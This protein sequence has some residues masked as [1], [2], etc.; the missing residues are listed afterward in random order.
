MAN[1]T[2]IAAAGQTF[3]TGSGVSGGFDGSLAAAGKLIPDAGDVNAFRAAMG[4]SAAASGA[5]PAVGGSLSSAV[6]DGL[7]AAAEAY[8]SRFETLHIGLKKIEKT[9]SITSL[10][11]WQLNSAKMGVEMEFTGKIISKAVQDVEQLTKQQG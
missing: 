9:Q 4:S 7:K 3:Q 11:E 1:T 6:T 8:R 2:S 10:L 5:S